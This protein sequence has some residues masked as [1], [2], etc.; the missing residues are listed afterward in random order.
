MDS[1]FFPISTTWIDRIRC[2]LVKYDAITIRR[3]QTDSPKNNR[4]SPIFL[5]WYHNQYKL[6]WKLD[7]TTNTSNFHPFLVES[8]F[9]K[10]KF[11][12]ITNTPT[13]HLLY[14][15]YDNL[16]FHHGRG[17]LFTEKELKVNYENPEAFI[18]KFRPQ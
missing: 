15:I 12:E 5:A 13:K 8:P 4:E 9:N 17:S 3:K 1:D 7:K 11:L 18:S 16:F 14:C 6:Y 2:D 10:L